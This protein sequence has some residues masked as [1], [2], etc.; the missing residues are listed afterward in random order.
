[1]EAAW[2]V[3]TRQRF[4]YWD[5]L[6]VAAAQQQGCTV[7][8]TDDLQHDQRIDQLRILNPFLVGPEVLD[9]ATP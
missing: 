8:L 9:A 1:M 4:H 7:L 3:E 6:M 2:A 5:A